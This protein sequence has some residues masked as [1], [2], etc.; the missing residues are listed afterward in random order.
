MTR[1][2]LLHYVFDV[3]RLQRLP[4]PLSGSHVF[5]L[6]PQPRVSVNQ[7]SFV[8]SSCSESQGRRQSMDQGAK[9]I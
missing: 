5:E 7:H 9:I 1:R 3:V 8:K 6:R 2:I 4:E